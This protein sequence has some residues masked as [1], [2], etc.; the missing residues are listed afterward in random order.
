MKQQTLSIRKVLKNLL[1]LNNKKYWLYDWEVESFYC[2][3]KIQFVKK[4][5]VIVEVTTFTYNGKKR[6]A[7]RLKVTSKNM[8]RAKEL[9]KALS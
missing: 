5:G 4:Y 1:S 2:P 9:F 3:K 6:K 8:K 7:Y